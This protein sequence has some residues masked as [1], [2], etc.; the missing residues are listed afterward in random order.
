VERLEDGDESNGAS[1]VT[2]AA[3]PTTNL[4]RSVTPASA[5][6]AAGF[7][8]RFLVQIDPSTRALG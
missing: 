3:S 7:G 5:A 4:T 1:E 6:R 2:W 8:D